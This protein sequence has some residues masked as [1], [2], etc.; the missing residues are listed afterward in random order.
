MTKY[1]FFHFLW[2]ELSDILRHILKIFAVAVPIGFLSMILFGGKE[3]FKGNIG[4]I[5]LG[6]LETVLSAFLFL[7]L[8]CL[9]YCLRNYKKFR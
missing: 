8:A 1:G 6:L 2:S 7:F 9:I 4:G 3:P 5:L